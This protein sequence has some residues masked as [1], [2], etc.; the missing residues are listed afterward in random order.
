MVVNFLIG[1]K[2]GDFLIALYG[3]KGYCNL[4][5]VK[6]KVHLID[7]GWDFGIQNTY[8]A[9][10]PIMNQQEYISDFCILPSEHYT[11]DPIQTPKQNSPIIILDEQLKRDGYI[12]NNYLTS[13]L[14][15]KKCWLDI[16]STLYGFDVQQPTSWLTHNEIHSY[17]QDAVIL[18]RKFVPERFSTEFPYEQII[19]SY[20]KVVFVSTNEVDYLNFP[21][22]ESVEFR[23]IDTISDWF[24]AINSCR[25]YVGNLTGPVVIAEALDKLRILELPYNEDAHHWIGGDKYTSNLKW[26]LNNS[27]HNLN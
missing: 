13:P 24:T 17:Y 26:F 27:I 2:L 9:L 20:D 14:L 25:M 16:Y 11:L 23:K 15:Y 1:G 10:L 8:N 5:K 19:N 21:Y 4:H 3:V 22:K 12:S 18:H 6:A 7:I